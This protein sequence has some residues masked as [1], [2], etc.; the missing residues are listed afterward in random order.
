MGSKARE[1]RS[2]ALVV[3]SSRR[4]TGVL[5][6]KTKEETCTPC[7]PLALPPGEPSTGRRTHAAAHCRHTSLITSRSTIT[8]TGPDDR[9]AR[10]P[11]GG[12]SD[13]QAFSTIFWNSY[14]TLVSS[15]YLSCLCFYSSVVSWSLSPTCKKPSR[16]FL[17]FSFTTGSQ[18]KMFS[19]TLESLPVFKPSS[20]RTGSPKRVPCFFPP[21]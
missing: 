13:L 15:T 21:S 19:A 3:R 18:Y 20:R 12:C 17:L 4:M 2:E 7:G 9:M 1:V 6:L 10:Y 14:G 8:V 16:G 11:P 5:C